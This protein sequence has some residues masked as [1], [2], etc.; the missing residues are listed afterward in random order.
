LIIVGL[1][2]GIASGKTTVAKMLREKGAEIIDADDIARE[3]VQP[4]K[5]AWKEIV[6]WL[7]RDI[8]QEADH[9]DRS[10]L[11][12]IIFHSNEARS[13][14]NSIV[15]PWIEM[16]MEDKVN[17]LKLNKDI[18]VIVKD[19]PLLI[20]TGMYRSVDLVLLVWVSFEV[21]VIRLR[22]RDGLSDEEIQK[23]LN[24]Q[25][26]LEEKKKYA[27]Y[28]INNEISLDYTRSQV[29]H[30]WSWMISKFSD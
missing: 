2:G 29:D 22:K 14:L 16:R 11:G 15:H 4:G 26:P 24:A 5:P 27:D 3:V 1:T 18:E 28:V 8:L 25:M 17:S 10:K 23:R 30:F 19:V 21:Q 9:I 20:E 13:K 7:G 12:K 6:A